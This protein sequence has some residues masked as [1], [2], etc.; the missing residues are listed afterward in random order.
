ETAHERVERDR[1]PWVNEETVG[2]DPRGYLEESPLEPRRDLHIHIENEQHG[3]RDDGCD[4]PDRQPDPASGPATPCRNPVSSS[5]WLAPHSTTG[6]LRRW[7]LG[8]AS[9]LER[10]LEGLACLE[11][12]SA[13]R[14]DVERL[15]G[16]RVAARAGLSLSRLERS[17][18]ADRNLLPR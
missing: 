12:R 10:I 3:R 6:P 18:A 15:A 16:V 4:E 1:I 2:V 11:R 5:H 7:I 17:E 13:G 14:R 8:V 9:A